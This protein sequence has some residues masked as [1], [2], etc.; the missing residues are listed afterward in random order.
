MRNNWNFVKLDFLETMIQKLATL[1][2]KNFSIT[3]KFFP[4][5]KLCL[6][7]QTRPFLLGI[8]SEEIEKTSDSVELIFKLRV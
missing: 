4:S 1:E 6:A 2:P 3:L 7:V 8:I 5:L